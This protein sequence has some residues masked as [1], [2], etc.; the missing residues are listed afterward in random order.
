MNAEKLA[1]LLNDREYVTFAYEIACLY[2]TRDYR[3]IDKTI[4]EFY[5]EVKKNNVEQTS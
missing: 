5:T 3:K 1:K 4:E 2:G